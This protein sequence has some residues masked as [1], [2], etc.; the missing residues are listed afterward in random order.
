MNGWYG[1]RTRGAGENRCSPDDTFLAQSSRDTA[2]HRSLTIMQVDG[3]GSFVYVLFLRIRS[4]D[5]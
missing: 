4:L 5:G 2:V 1:V 3:D